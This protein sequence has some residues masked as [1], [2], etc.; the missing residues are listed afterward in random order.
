M[1]TLTLGWQH[2][3]LQPRYVSLTRHKAL[4]ES[5]P[6]HHRR[7]LVSQPQASPL[8]G[9]QFAVLRLAFLHAALGHTQQAKA[10]LHGAVRAAQVQGDPRAAVVAQALE[11]RLV[12]ADSGS[13]ATGGSAL[14]PGTRHEQQVKHL[15]QAIHSRAGAMHMW[16]LQALAAIGLQQPRVWVT[17]TC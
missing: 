9:T 1:L 11:A 2:H 13:A 12:E 16:R 14:H 4:G 5:H 15:L 6:S 17:L 3:S 7:R 10:A 8:A